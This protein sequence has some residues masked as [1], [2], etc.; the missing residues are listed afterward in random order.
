[1]VVVLVFVLVLVFMIVVEVLC[2]VMFSDVLWM[3]MCLGMCILVVVIDF[4]YGG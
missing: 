2:L 3:K 4:G 1:M